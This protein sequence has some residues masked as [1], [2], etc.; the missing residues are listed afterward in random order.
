MAEVRTFGFRLYYFKQA[1]ARLHSDSIIPP[2]LPSRD[3]CL[4]PEHGDQP[5]TFRLGGCIDETARMRPGGAGA[6]DLRPP[7]RIGVRVN[8]FG[9]NGI[10]VTVARRSF[11]TTFPAEF[12]LMATII[13]TP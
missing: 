6:L 1:G 13:S 8:R 11:S 7:N 2:V 3:R 4:P 5:R 10:P 9:L 12:V